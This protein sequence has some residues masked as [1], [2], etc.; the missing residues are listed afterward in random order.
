MDKSSF[1]ILAF[2]MAG[3]VSA[4]LKYNFTPAQIFREIQVLYYWA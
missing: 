1:A 3:A 2:A 4:F